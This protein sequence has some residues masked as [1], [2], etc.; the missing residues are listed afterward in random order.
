MKKFYKSNHADV[1]AAWTD[2]RNKTNTLKAEFT[3]FANNFD[4]KPVFS[5]SVNGHKFAN[6]MLNNYGTRPDGSLWTRPKPALGNTSHIKAR[7]QGKESMAE[8]RQLKA[9]FK[10]LKPACSE[11]SLD[12]LY[13]TLGISWSDVVF[14][15]IEWFAFDGDVYISTSLSITQNV[16]E[17][18]AHEFSIA[19]QS[20]DKVD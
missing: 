1:Y 5:Y 18:T 13:Q 9:K 20:K 16:D 2:Y 15:G 14:T 17:I 11:V 4:A 7:V 8:L 10:E 19:K 6:L 12:E 3:E